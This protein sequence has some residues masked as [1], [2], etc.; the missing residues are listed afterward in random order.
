MT[1]LQAYCI[2]I[3]YTA[4]E[5]TAKSSKLSD[6]GK[7][8]GASASIKMDLGDKIRPA[9]V[10]RSSSSKSVHS[11]K[12]TSLDDFEVLSTIGTGSY[13]TCKKIKRRKDGKVM[14]WKE[15][16]YGSMTE[17]EKQMLV[18]EVN[19]LRELKSPYIVRYYDR[20]IDRARTTIYIIMEYCKGGDL[21]TLIARCKRDALYQD[22]EFIW[23][24]LIQLTLALFECHQR[25]NG[26]AVLHRDMKPANV[27]L[28]TDRN[29]KLGDFGLARVLHHETSFANTYVGTPYYM[30]PELV[31][32]M[33]YNEKSDVWSMGCVL[34]ELCALHPPFTASS[35]TELN[36]KIRL[37]DFERIPARY[38]DDLNAVIAKMLNVEVLKRPSIE[39]ILADPIVSVRHN[40]LERRTSD[41]NTSSDLRSWESELRVLEMQL[42]ERKSKLDDRER[43]LTLREKLLEEKEKSAVVKEKIADERMSRAESLLLEYERKMRSESERLLRGGDPRDASDTSS[44]G[45]ASCLLKKKESDLKKKVSFDMYGKENQRLKDRF[46]DPLAKYSDYDS[47]YIQEL[48]KR[49]DLKERL[50]QAKHRP[51]D[52]RGTDDRGARSRNLLLFR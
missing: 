37:G 9:S 11:S 2:S 35:Q 21:S 6:Q 26:R 50:Y 38:S 41:Q 8:V 47:T 14:V 27:F 12:T 51:L 39:E 36:R 1:P 19:L 32:N 20:I 4:M 5:N 34:Y 44:D 23:K 22:E 7:A 49:Q 30:S 42:E 31:N 48:L 43:E 40:K 25:K 45:L 46:G 17:T 16:D 18:S 29:V 3:V 24:I 33:S 15:L 52:Y 13:G 28:D 10:H